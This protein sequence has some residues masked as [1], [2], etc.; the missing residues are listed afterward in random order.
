[1][2]SR[3]TVKEK[4]AGF[5]S[6]FKHRIGSLV[7]TSQS[8]RD[9]EMPV[10]NLVMF[11]S[12]S[13]GK[14][15]AVNTILGLSEFAEVSESETHHKCVKRDGVIC[16]HKVTLV[17][18]PKLSNTSLSQKDV[19]HEAYHALSLCSLNINT[20]LLVLTVDPLTDD[21]KGEL[22][23]ISDIFDTAD[24]RFWDCLIIMFIYE[25][26]RQDE[27]V[28]EFINVNKDIQRLLKKCE[29]KYYILSVKQRPDS[30][31]LSEF[32]QMIYT[33]TCY[34]S[35]TYME[36]QM[37]NRIQLGARIGKVEEEIRALKKLNQKDVAL[38]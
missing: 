25:G 37:D 1:M 12:N 13:A 36:A 26:N 11:G 33:V 21:D 2:P 6:D 15:L 30:T 9:K 32:L 14:T 23:L 24:G 3:K 5:S 28:T 35:T 31:Q 17:K 16:G 18:M 4:F 34:T 22:E 20:F 7:Q 8:T 27:I 10:L 29:N 38:A 19:L